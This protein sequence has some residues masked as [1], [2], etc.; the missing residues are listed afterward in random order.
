MKKSLRSL[1]LKALRPGN[2][3]AKPIR[4]EVPI[5]DPVG[6]EVLGTEPETRTITFRKE[7]LLVISQLRSVEAWC[8]E[9]GA[10]VPR[11]STKQAATIATVSEEEI[12]GELEA[13]H[14]HGARTNEAEGLICLNSLLKHM[15]Q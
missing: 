13:G 1:V 3:R 8:E 14:L 5:H 15:G 11:L 4:N 12:F 2:S 6:P 9:C 10:T 7:R